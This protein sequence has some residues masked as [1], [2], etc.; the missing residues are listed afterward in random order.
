[1]LGTLLGT[2]KELLDSKKFVAGIS[3]AAVA[4]LLAWAAKK[5]YIIEKET[6]DEAAKIIIGSAS[7]YV[8]SQGIADH[9]KERVKEEA[10]LPTTP[11]PTP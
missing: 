1:M 10:K 6:A 7:A 9:G 2:I 4:I 8:V 5:G 11:T 3:S